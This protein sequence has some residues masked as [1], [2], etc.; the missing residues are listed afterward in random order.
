[1]PEIHFLMPDGETKTIDADENASLMVEA[2]KHK[3][4]GIDGICGGSMACATCHVY[5]HPDWV[6]KVLAED[7]EKTDEE[8]DTLDV[9]FDIRDTSRLSCQIKITPALDG[10]IVAL[11]GT[12][13]DW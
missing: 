9:A 10:L 4:H 8:E 5:V 11:P 2:L 12:K 13:T 7:N 3:I 1:M 6:E